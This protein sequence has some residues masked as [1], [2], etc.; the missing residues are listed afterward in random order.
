MA[1]KCEKCGEELLGAVNRCWRCGTKVELGVPAAAHP[2][3]SPVARPPA[4]PPAE[5]PGE[6]VVLAALVQPPARKETAPPS[7]VAPIT[8][9]R[10]SHLR[11]LTAAQG[12]AVAALVLGLMSV[13]AS[14]YTELA[15]IPAALGLGLGAWGLFSPRRGPAI[16]GLLLC[17]LALAIASFTG[18]VSLYKQAYGHAP[19]EA[20]AEPA[21]PE[22]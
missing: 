9:P 19:W 5:E 20:P 12:G 16:L 8:P 6:D 4:A 2:P 14:F 11:R 21:E 13:V 10:S 22:F 7:P 1:L 18:A 15:A 3:P 17:F